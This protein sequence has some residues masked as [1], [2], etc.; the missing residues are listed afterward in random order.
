[1]ITHLGMRCLVLLSCFGQPLF[2]IYFTLG[3]VGV[4]RGDMPRD[5]VKWGPFIRPQCHIPGK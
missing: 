4:E 3:V 2:Y 1:M 5:G